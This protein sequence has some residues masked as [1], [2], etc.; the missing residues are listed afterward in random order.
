MIARKHEATMHSAKRKI[1]EITLECDESQEIQ[2][3]I[4]TICD[5]INDIKDLFNNASPGAIK[6]QARLIR[7]NVEKF[8][9]LV[10]RRYPNDEAKI[11][12]YHCSVHELINSFLTNS[13]RVDMSALGSLYGLL[14]TLQKVIDAFINES[15]KN[16]DA[17]ALRTC[18]GYVTQSHPKR[19]T[20]YA[21]TFISK[22]DIES[23]EFLREQFAA[24]VNDMVIVAAREGQFAY[25]DTLRIHHNAATN[26]I[27]VG[28]DQYLQTTDIDQVIRKITKMNLE[29]MLWIYENLSS[30][31]PPSY[32]KI[33]QAINLVNVMKMEHG[34]ALTSLLNKQDEHDYSKLNL[35]QLSAIHR[36]VKQLTVIFALWIPEQDISSIPIELILK[37]ASHLTDL[38]PK[39]LNQVYYCMML[40]LQRT[41][42]ISNLDTISN[43]PFSMFREA[44]ARYLPECQN[45]KTK[46]KMQ[47]LLDK[48]ADEGIYQRRIIPT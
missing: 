40:R 34:S 31:S 47:A 7:D 5:P 42:V 11:I 6:S 10:K 33:E 26:Y 19:Y 4:D 1:G 35:K 23:A 43:T 17:S 24:D 14:V 12:D 8:L 37:I 29:L 46:V 45:T 13:R 16:R 28:L 21:K 48:M 32:L 25:V 22:G 27:L 20:F 9:R 41:L 30:L 18:F 3:Y 44:A 15:V 2:M 39:E 36:H 38:S